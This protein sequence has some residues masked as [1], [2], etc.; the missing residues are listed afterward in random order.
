MNLRL[1]PLRFPQR[2]KA[3]LATALIPGLKAGV[4]PDQ[5]LPNM[6]GNFSKVIHN[7]PQR[8]GLTGVR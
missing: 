4:Y 3:H 7:L 6:Q 8:W 1:Q 5:D 2:L